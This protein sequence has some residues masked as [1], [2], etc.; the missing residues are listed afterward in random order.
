MLFI[1]PWYTL[2]STPVQFCQS[3]PWAQ[4]RSMTPSQASL[5]F[6]GGASSEEPA[7]AGD[8]RDADLI[9]GSGRS[10]GV[11]NGTLL[12][13]SCL[14]DSMDRGAWKPTVH[15]ATKSRTR[16][17]AHIL[18]HGAVENNPQG[19]WVSRTGCK[20]LMGLQDSIEAPRVFQ[21]TP[22]SNI[23]YHIWER[24]GSLQ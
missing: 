19:D 15:E 16:M 2:D 7:D 9:P 10:P 11:G 18:H 14:E 5:G 8:S 21:K 12:K 23:P 13:Y 22:Q 24:R 6:P 1:T 17:S 4:I 3:I 20:Q